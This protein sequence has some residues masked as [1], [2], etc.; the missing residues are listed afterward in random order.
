M[1]RHRRIALDSCIFIYELDEN[2]RYLPLADD[3]FGWLEHAN[4]QAFTSTLTMTD[5]LVQPYRLDDRSRV[6]RFYN[7]LSTY[8]NL[9]WISPDLKIADIA[10]RI[11]AQHRL[12]TPD[13]IQAA[14]AIHS[15]V[16]ALITNDPIFARVPD[17]DTLVLDQLL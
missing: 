17:F 2:A 12:R 6:N 7:L 15:R 4:S 5:V 1:T 13:A 8:P 16:T 10:A 11:R 14:T 9:V 3:I